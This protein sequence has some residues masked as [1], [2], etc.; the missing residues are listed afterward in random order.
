LQRS[1]TISSNVTSGVNSNTGLA[2]T[3]RSSTD[4]YRAFFHDNSGSLSEIR[5]C[6]PNITW[7]TGASV[8]SDTNQKLSG[9]TTDGGANLTTYGID[10]SGKIL[11]S[12][13]ASNED[14][15]KCKMH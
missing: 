8:I 9:I 14:W 1:N 4:G 10:G 2:A 12:T 5:Y 11:S 15:L 6:N 3:L 13:L 7:G